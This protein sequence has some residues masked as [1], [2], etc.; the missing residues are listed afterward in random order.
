MQIDNFDIQ[1]FTEA[2]EHFGKPLPS[3]VRDVHAQREAL[4]HVTFT[5]VPEL[6]E[7]L[8]A[9]NVTKAIHDQAA[10]ITQN[11]AE[12]DLTQ[13][14]R[15]N[16]NAQ[17]PKV[18][19]AVETM[20]ELFDTLKPVF[21]NTVDE[22]KQCMSKIPAGVEGLTAEAAVEGSYG[23]T[24]QRILELEEDI[25]L[26]GPVHSDIVRPLIEGDASKPWDGHLY[27][28]LTKRRHLIRPTKVMPYND[29]PYLERGAMVENIGEEF[30]HWPS[31]IAASE[32]LELAW[33]TPLEMHIN[34]E[35]MNGHENPDTES[36]RYFKA[37]DGHRIT[38]KAA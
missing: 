7:K 23:D 29:R 30:R 26:L 21:D 10:I 17:L 13:A 27:D 25:R 34:Q 3:T 12:H 9:K 20:W 35:R 15:R 28:N 16:I 2:L 4:Q 22:L 36:I 38:T 31:I 19:G 11:K 37:R 8:T 1:K 6:P 32:G 18:W 33:M 5:V 24:Y 14:L